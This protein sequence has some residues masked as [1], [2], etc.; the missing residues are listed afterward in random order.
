MRYKKKGA[1]AAKISDKAIWIASRNE[2]Q[3]A[4]Y[5]EAED[6]GL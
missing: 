4:K 3:H 5:Y 1:A 2:A 6:A